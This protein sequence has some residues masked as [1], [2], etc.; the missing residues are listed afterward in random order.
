MGSIKNMSSRY[1]YNTLILEDES[2]IYIPRCSYQ[3]IAIKYVSGQFELKYNGRRWLE[4]RVVEDYDIVYHPRYKKIG[5][6]IK[7]CQAMRK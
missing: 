4:K 6:N 1:R 3:N 7:V 2:Y 5:R